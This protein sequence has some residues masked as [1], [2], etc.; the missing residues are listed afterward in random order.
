[1]SLSIHGIGDISHE[2][3]QDDNGYKGQH[4]TG[5]SNIFMMSTI[6]QAARHGGRLTDFI[7]NSFV[8]VFVDAQ[9]KGDG[10]QFGKG[11]FGLAIVVQP[12]MIER[13]SGTSIVTSRTWTGTSMLGIINEKTIPKAIAEFF[14]F[15]QH[16]LFRLSMILFKGFGIDGYGINPSLLEGV[17]MTQMHIGSWIIHLDLSGAVI[18]SRIKRGFADIR[19]DTH[20]GGFTLQGQVAGTG[21]T[22]RSTVSTTTATTPG[23]TGRARRRSSERSAAGKQQIA[24]TGRRRKRF[25]GGRMAQ[26]QQSTASGSSPTMSG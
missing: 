21:Q 1:M 19:D 7:Q 9:T 14:V 23:C 20:E 6:K 8:N 15:Q 3:K 11:I 22:G 12:M 17:T 16:G 2:T 10:R 26:A 13:M 25:A 24:K 5:M 18:E 4:D